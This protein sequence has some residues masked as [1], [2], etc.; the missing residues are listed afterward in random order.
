MEPQTV[1]VAPKAWRLRRRIGPL[2]WCAL[3]ALVAR[4]HPEGG[5]LVAQALV[6]TIAD[7]LG[8]AHNTA[9]RALR[10]LRAAGLIEH[11]QARANAGLFDIAHYALTVPAD[12]LQAIARTPDLPILSARSPRRNDRRPQPSIVEQLSFSL[13]D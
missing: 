3:E 11:C 12:E 4:S 9:L 2:P 13:T 10:S 6:R 1:M 5:V 8:V 7:D